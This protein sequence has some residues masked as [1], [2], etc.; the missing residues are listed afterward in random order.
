MTVHGFDSG[1]LARINNIIARNYVETG[2]I[3]GS[4]IQIWRGD[5]LVWSGMSGSIDLAR[6]VAMREDAIFRI[7]SMTK[8]LTAVALL[9][10]M[11]EG[12][13][14]LDDPVSRYIPGFANLGVYAGGT[15]GA[16]LSAPNVKPMKVV[17]LLRH[18]SGL[19]YGFLNRTN[20]DAAYRKL[21][22]AEANSEGGLAAMI[23]D[24]EKLPLEFAPGEM[25]NYSVSLDVVGWLV[26]KI[27]GQ[28]F[29]DF[30]KTR[31]LSPLGM[32]DT[33]F[34]IPTAKRDRFATCYYVK[35][36]KLLVFDDAQN[37][38][39]AQPPQLESGGGGLAGTAAD[40]MRFCRML[41][42]GGELDGVR[43]LSP[44]TVALMTMNH[45]PGRRTMTEM[46]PVTGAFN[47]SG[48]AGVG[49]GLGVAVTENV[50]ATGI[51]GTAGEYSWGGAAGTYF[52][53]DPK[54]E[55]AVVF[56]TQVLFA[57]DRIKLRRDLRSLVYGAMSESYVG[58]RR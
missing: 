42:N 36:G 3:P 35:D 20:L 18:T 8:P 19:T 4:L 38:T 15:L 40:Y 1:R 24:L 55:L 13:V 53:N 27:S 11:E 31:I 58:A 57:A 51:P 28:R 56:M 39:Y 49:Y 5:E 12:L 46:M 7:Y 41:L 30:L 6:G 9:M 34:Q 32:H 44:K 10:L 23:A 54:E 29:S 2:A 50:A 33:D 52:F 25:W 21:H 47:E 45:L 48:Y 22:I 37:S 43:L 26:E 16:F 17:D 14:A